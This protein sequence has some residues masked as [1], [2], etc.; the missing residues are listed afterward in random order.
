MRSRLDVAIAL[1]VRSRR[2]SRYHA[3][4]SSGSGTGSSSSSSRWCVARTR[5]RTFCKFGTC[6]LWDVWINIACDPTASE[7]FRE[8]PAVWA[9]PGGETCP[10]IESRS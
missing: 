9:R 6:D 2:A 1:L 3:W 8:V 10:V 4:D 5:R 7:V